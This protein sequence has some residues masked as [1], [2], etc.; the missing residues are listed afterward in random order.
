MKDLTV[1]LEDLNLF[2]TRLGQ[3]LSEGAMVP[4]APLAP[5]PMLCSYDVSRASFLKKR[6]SYSQ[7]Q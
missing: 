6:D 4:L 3:K 1:L 7:S 2:A 5:L